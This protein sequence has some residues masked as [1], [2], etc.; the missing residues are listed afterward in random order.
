VVVQLIASSPTSNQVP[1]TSNLGLISIST[2][3]DANVALLSGQN[4]YCYN[5]T[6]QT[7]FST[8]PQVAIGPIC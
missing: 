4:Y 1:F 8:T 2:A 6:L 5:Y 7:V 3:T